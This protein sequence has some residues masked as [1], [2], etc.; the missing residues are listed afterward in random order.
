MLSLFS[1]P[2][3][4]SFGS[5]KSVHRRGKSLYHLSLVKKTLPRS[6]RNSFASTANSQSSHT[7]LI[8]DVSNLWVVSENSV[9]FRLS[10][11]L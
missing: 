10:S 3:N 8:Q 11:N 1:S 6:Q 5:E 4:S 9:I 7:S 2:I